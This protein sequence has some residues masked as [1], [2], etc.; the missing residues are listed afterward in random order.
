MMNKNGYNE[1]LF[2]CEDGVCFL[3]GAIGDTARHELF[4]GKNRANSKRTG[5]WITVCPTCHRM[6]H[7]NEVEEELHRIGECRFLGVS[8]TRDDF[9]TIFGRDYL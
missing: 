2:D 5:L 3:C 1:S 6:A 7:T 4:R 9:K 8:G